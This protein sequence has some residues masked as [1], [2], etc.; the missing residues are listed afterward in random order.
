MRRRFA[1]ALLGMSLVLSVGALGALTPQSAQAEENQFL[2]GRGMADMTGE[3]GENGMMGYG[4]SRQLSEGIHSRQFA[5]AYIVQDPNT[6]KRVAFLSGDMLSGTNLERELLLKKLKENYGDR[7]NDGNVLIAATHTHA[8]PGGTTDYSLYN[9][10]TMGVHKQSLD[11]TVD[12]FAKAIERAEADMAPSEISFGADKVT[13]AGVNRSLDAFM[14]NPKELR[15]KLPGNRDARSDTMAISRNGKVTGFVNWMATHATTLPTEN[16]LIS[17]DN[18]GYAEYLD[19]VKE[20]GDDY[21][22]LDNPAMVAAYVYSNGADQTPNLGLKPATGPSKDPYKSVEIMGR[23][24]HDGA[25]RSLAKLTAQRDTTV[26]YRIVWVDMQ[27]QQ[28][29]PEF[30][31]TGKE[32]KTCRAIVGAPFGSGSEEDGGGGVTFLGEGLDKNELMDSLT[33][34]TYEATP[35]LR[36]CQGPKK[37]LFESGMVDGVQ[38]KLPVQVLRIG[39]RYIL[40]MPGEVTSAS[41][42]LMREAFAK[43]AG[44]TVDKVMI[45]SA[46]NAYAHY[47]TT[48]W[49]YDRQNYEGGATIF[50]RYTVPALNQVLAGI[51][52]SF[53]TGGKEVVGEAPNIR[54]FIYSA[55]GRVLHDTPGGK[56]YGDVLIPVRSAYERGSVVKAVFQGAHPNVNIRH[57]G[58]YMQVQKQE[59]DKWVDVAKDSDFS[60]KFIWKRKGISASEVT[61][62]WDTAEAEPGTYRMV[63]NG[64]SRAPGNRDSEF[65]GATGS[66]RVE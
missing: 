14:N 32:E 51:G 52:K 64:T 19:E 46:A 1:S 58:T 62:Q 27:N 47:F 41:G 2:A 35:G 6:N 13:D 39:D 50:G 54:P 28:V 10:T 23:R 36:G 12:G 4:D 3:P 30:S 60:T 66:F 49:E 65:Q 8:T 20:A 29:A 16:K 45:S 57:E 22:K 21:T 59:G 24:I 38:T 56:H 26:D 43:T 11:A 31:T 25:S 17:S 55:Y 37:V 42:V 44:T 40:G 5:R 61:L 18:K 63:Y 9:V 48:P 33:K 7:Y 34:T 53:K 15:D